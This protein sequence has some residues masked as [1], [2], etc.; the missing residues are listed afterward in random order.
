MTRAT[1]TATPSDALQPTAIAITAAGFAPG[2][3]VRITSTLVDDAGVTWAAHGQFVADAQG[4]IDLATAPSEH[5]TYE[6]VD[7]AGLLWSMRPPS[8]TDRQFMIDATEKAHKLGSPHID[9]I[10]PQV[11][12]LSASTD[13]QLRASTTLSLRRLDDGIEQVT[14]RDG[15]LR[16][17]VFRWKERRLPDGRKRGCI[18]TFTGSGGGL[19]LGYAPVLASLSYDVVCLAYFAYDDLPKFIAAIP[20]EYFE[21]GFQWAQRE[22]G[23]ETIAIQGASRGGELVM[24]LASFLPEYVQGVIGIVPMYTTSVGWDPAKGFGGPS[25]TFRGEPIPHSGSGDDPDWD[26]MRRIGLAEPKGYALTPEYRKTLEEPET[27]ANPLPVDRA[28]GPVLLISG[29]DDQMWPSAWGSDL[30][31]SR[32]R[33]KAFKHPYRHLCL[34]ETGHITPFPNTVTTFTPAVLHSLLGI[35]L[36]CGGTPAGT[37]RT[38]RQTWDAMVAHYHSVF[39]Y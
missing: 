39:G 12:E 22:L 13:G 18:F 9:P 38:S 3:T 35:F 23:A 26:R 2:E 34:K 17:Q 30:I 33:A 19:E 1:L 25:F 20:L 14:L 15:R 36:A 7:A 16:G 10:K 4:E 37:A 11:F 32:L 29:V 24:A 21:E 31:V 8:G 28:G 6:G 5:G 27:R